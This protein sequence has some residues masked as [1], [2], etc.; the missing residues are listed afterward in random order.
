MSTKVNLVGCRHASER[1]TRQ[2]TEPAS[3]SLVFLPL[4]SDFV[5]ISLE[6][7]TGF[8]PAGSVAFDVR[9]EICHRRWKHHSL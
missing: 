6:T 4:G 2:R 3:P 7:V 5:S 9:Q 8:V 1:P